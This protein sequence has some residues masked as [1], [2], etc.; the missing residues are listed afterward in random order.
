MSTPAS[1]PQKEKKQSEKRRRAAVIMSDDDDDDDESETPNLNKYADPTYA[2]YFHEPVHP[3]YDKMYD[4]RVV[5]EQKHNEAGGRSEFSHS[6]PTGRESY[7]RMRFNSAEELIDWDA[8]AQWGDP[9]SD[10]DC[11]EI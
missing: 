4:W 1:N 7:K 5:N 3:E 8:S 11:Y 6:T 9:G 10:G 2:K